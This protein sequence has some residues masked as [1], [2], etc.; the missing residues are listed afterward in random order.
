MVFGEVLLLL[1]VPHGVQRGTRGSPQLLQVP[2]RAGR[3]VAPS[4]SSCCAEVSCLASPGTASPAEKDERSP[5]VPF[6]PVGSGAPRLLPDTAGG[7][8]GR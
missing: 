6:M 8:R 2:R 5:G 1:F 7:E 3:A 4:Q